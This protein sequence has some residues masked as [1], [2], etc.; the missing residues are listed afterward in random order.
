M[1]ERMMGDE[2]ES[3]EDVGWICEDGFVEV[4]ERG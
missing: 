3:D 2:C 1:L 4:V